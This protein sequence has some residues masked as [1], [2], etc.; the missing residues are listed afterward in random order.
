MLATGRRRV[1]KRTDALRFA[2]YAPAATPKAA[3]DS[4]YA[5][6]EKQVSPRAAGFP[7]AGATQCSLR[8]REKPRPASAMPRSASVAG[9]GT[10]ALSTNKPTRDCYVPRKV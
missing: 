10:V 1:V 2:I 4:G 7:G 5:I 8:R 9:S 3:Q 6:A